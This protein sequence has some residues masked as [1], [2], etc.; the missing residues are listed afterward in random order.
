MKIAGRPLFWLIIALLVFLFWK[1]PE[2]M[3]AALSGLG[4]AFAVI[5][6]GLAKLLGSMTHKPAH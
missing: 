5:G 3:S 4:H 2:P 6:D 1:A